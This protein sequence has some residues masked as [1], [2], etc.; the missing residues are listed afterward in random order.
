M[1]PPAAA[2]RARRSRRAVL[3]HRRRRWPGTSARPR[4]G[5]RSSWCATG[6]RTR[7]TPTPTTPSGGRPACARACSRPRAS[8]R[9]WRG[10]SRGWRRTMPA[11]ILAGEPLPRAALATDRH[12]ACGGGQRRPA[13]RRAVLSAQ[14]PSPAAHAQP[15]GELPAASEPEHGARAAPLADLAVTSTRPDRAPRTVP[16]TSTNP[17]AVRRARSVTLACRTTLAGRMPAAVGTGSRTT[18]RRGG[19]AA[20]GLPA[21]GVG[22]RPSRSNTA[23][24]AG[25]RVTEAC[26]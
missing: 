13:R 10:S 21:A 7:S 4:A 19:A 16:D 17:R 5:S 3:G 26:F 9:R 8:C 22:S 2:A 23:P 15:L 1:R 20:G 12:G 11:A 6:S 14:P 24:A 25:P 18:L